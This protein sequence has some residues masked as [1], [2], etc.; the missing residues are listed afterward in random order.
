MEEKTPA[1]VDDS[2]GSESES[3]VSQSKMLKWLICLKVEEKPI[4]AQPSGAR[5]RSTTAGSSYSTVSELSPPPVYHAPR[6]AQNPRLHVVMHQP[7]SGKGRKGTPAGVKGG[8]R[9]SPA[10]KPPRDPDAPKR[11]TNAFLRFCEEERD[12]VRAL[13]G[14]D[15]NFD[16]T[17]AMG[18]AWHAL[19]DAQKKPYKEAFNEDQKRYKEDMALYE[20]MKRRA[21]AAG[22]SASHHHHHHHH[23]HRAHPPSRMEDIGSAYG[24]DADS[25][26][27]DVVDMTNLTGRESPDPMDGGE[28]ASNVDVHTPA[29][30]STPGPSGGFTAV[31]KRSSGLDPNMVK[32]ED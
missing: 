5:R 1:H 2:E 26:D 29:E 18:Q 7:A 20:A 3:S 25:E 16:L 23:H 9:A 28:T 11:P 22:Q 24:D 8:H 17:K 32:R 6:Q 21:E 27:G 19:T 4:R 10:P 30:G 15:E 13:H 14:G 31:N 12:N